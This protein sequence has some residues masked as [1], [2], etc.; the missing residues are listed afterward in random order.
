MK[1]GGNLLCKMCENE[2]RMARAFLLSLDYIWICHVC[3]KRDVRFLSIF[4]LISNY[5][6]NKLLC[7]CKK[8]THLKQKKGPFYSKRLDTFHHFNKH[9]KNRRIL[10]NYKRFLCNVKREFRE[11]L[12]GLGICLIETST[13]MKW[14]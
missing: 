4:L 11:K 8:W 9:G 7:R 12:V 10:S 13:K 2:M 3:L 6:I 5:F 1:N 14:N